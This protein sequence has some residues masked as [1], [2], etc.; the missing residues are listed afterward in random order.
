MNFDDVQFGFMPERGASD[1]IF[2]L[3]EKK[4]IGKDRN[5]YFPFVELQ[6]LRQGA[7]EGP[8]VGFNESRYTR[9]DCACGSDNVSKCKKSSE[10]KKLV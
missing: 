8:M 2:I 4:Y 7:Q 10:D 1:T 3:N 5:L 6:D 9:V